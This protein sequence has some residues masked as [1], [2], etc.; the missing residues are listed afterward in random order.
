MGNLLATHY[1]RPETVDHY[2]S[3]RGLTRREVRAVENYFP[4]GARVLDLGCGAGRTTEGFVDLGFDVVGVDL[5]SGMVDA[6]KKAVPDAAYAVSNAA[7]LGFADDTFDAVLFSH[8]GLDNVL[9]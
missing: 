4:E 3:G 5:S 9:P 2:T 6:A 8:F 7:E 1:E